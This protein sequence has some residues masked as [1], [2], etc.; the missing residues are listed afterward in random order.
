M[1]Q[2]VMNSIADVVGDEE[3]LRC[4]GWKGLVGWFVDWFVGWLVGCSVGWLIN[5][6]LGWLMGW[7]GTSPTCL[8]TSPTCLFAH[9]LLCLLFS[10]EGDQQ[11]FIQEEVRETGVNINLSC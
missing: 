9:V 7:L 3:K 11:P 2:R 6:L 5:W 1:T 10:A 4:S 8:S